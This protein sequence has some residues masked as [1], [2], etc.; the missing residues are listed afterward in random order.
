MFFVKGFFFLQ[1][2]KH[3]ILGT[4]YLIITCICEFK[5]QFFCQ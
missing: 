3:H 1:G 4:I 5:D 2:I